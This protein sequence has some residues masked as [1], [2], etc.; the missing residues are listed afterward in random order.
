[1]RS[2]IAAA[3][4]ASAAALVPRQALCDFDGCP[5]VS[6]IG[7]GTLHLGD[8]ISGITTAEEVNAWILN[9]HAQGITLFDLA[10]VIIFSL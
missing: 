4:L 6:R 2:L 10:D 3:A 8:D 1:M 5:T 9:A 7:M